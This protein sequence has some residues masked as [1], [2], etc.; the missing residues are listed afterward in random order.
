MMTIIIMIKIMKIKTII[1]LMIIIV[2]VIMM[3]KKVEIWTFDYMIIENKNVIKY[4]DN[5][6]SYN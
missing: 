5:N 1:K 2:V 6:N 3:I 4:N